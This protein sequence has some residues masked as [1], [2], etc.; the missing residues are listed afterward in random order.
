MALGKGAISLIAAASS[1]AVLEA[2]WHFGA[3]SAPGWQIAR[4]AAEGATVGGL[5]DW[6]AVSALFHR[7]P[8][9]LLS[10]HT[11]IV[12]R[13][14]K[15]VTEKL[16]EL[17]KSEWLARDSVRAH[18]ETVNF[19]DALLKYMEQPE[20]RDAI[21]E[22]AR[23]GGRQLAQQIASDKAVGWLEDILD[24]QVKSEAVRDYLTREILDALR[25]LEESEGFLRKWGTKV[26]K[27]LIDGETDHHKAAGLAETILEKVTNRLSTGD[28][29]RNILSHTGGTLTEQLS[30]SGSAL[31]TELNTVIDN[32]LESLRGDESLRERIDALFN[33]AILGIL[34]DGREMI[35]NIVRTS[36]SRMPDEAL[37]GQIETLVGDELQWIRVNGALVGGAA[38][39]LFGAIR[40]VFGS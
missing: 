22:Y 15:R 9:P 1:L 40:Y 3:L 27:M 26:A 35:G 8:I 11:D 4:G 17:V 10:R 25:E 30:D 24:G 38:A 5:A 29:V 7:V 13:R 31:N 6:F 21:Y 28:L 37:V 14:R 2:L 34:E 32:M 33:E 23:S 36:L 20:K 39:G 12:R 18:L 16:A 19:G